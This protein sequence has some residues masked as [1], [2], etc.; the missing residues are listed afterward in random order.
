V[1][2]EVFLSRIA[3]RSTS[4]RLLL[5]VGCATVG[6][7]LTP[8]GAVATPACTFNVTKNVYDGPDWWGT[9]TFK[10]N[11]PASSSNYIV[12]FDVPTGVHCTNDYVPPG[13]TL[14]PL[15]GSGSSARTTSNHC[16]F[17][18]TNASAIGA[19]LSKTFNYSTDSQ[20][21]SSASNLGVSDSVCSAGFFD[22][23]ILADVSL[24][25]I[26]NRL[27]YSNL[28]ASNS[29]NTAMFTY[30]VDGVG[31]VEQH[32]F[33]GPTDVQYLMRLNGADVVFAHRA[34]SNMYGPN[35]CGDGFGSD[36]TGLKNL[37]L[38]SD[39]LRA[40]ARA[41][42]QSFENPTVVFALGS[43]GRATMGNMGDPP[44]SCADLKAY[45]QQEFDRCLT[46]DLIVGGGAAVL[47]GEI[48]AAGCTTGIFCAVAAIAGGAIIAGAVATHI[49][50]C[51]EQYKTCTAQ[52]CSTSETCSSSMFP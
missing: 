47:G 11:G 7:A 19:G 24:A 12:A 2:N 4:R 13:A 22:Q 10:N 35:V 32:V 37:H 5:W 42:I 25:R 33:V 38:S 34:K 29:Q 48:I 45:C 28:S 16:V 23:N 50:A 39:K 14:S 36:N 44:T 17:T 46:F 49:L 15:T 1:T 21:F 30:T 20:S 31:T 27:L 41:T 51:R 18:W 3:S 40:L 43:A 52:A 26:E 8:A 6:L 9:I